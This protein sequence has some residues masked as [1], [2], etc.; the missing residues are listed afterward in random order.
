MNAKTKKIVD[1][2]ITDNNVK[3][4]SGGIICVISARLTDEGA[5]VVFEDGRKL[6]LL[7]LNPKQKALNAAIR[8]EL[9]EKEKKAEVK[10]EKEAAKAKTDAAHNRAMAKAKKEKGK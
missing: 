4:P 9:A 8:K 10:A 6:E 2:L 7:K 3:P 1:A 5:I